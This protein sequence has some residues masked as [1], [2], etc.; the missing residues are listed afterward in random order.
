MAPVQ[1][2]LPA[3]WPYVLDAI[4]RACTAGAIVRD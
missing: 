4:E 3:L 1:S 2:A